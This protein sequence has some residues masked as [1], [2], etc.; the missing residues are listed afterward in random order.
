VKLRN[1]DQSFKSITL[2]L[3]LFVLR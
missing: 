2:P 3:F 1:I